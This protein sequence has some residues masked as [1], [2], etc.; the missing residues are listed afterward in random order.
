MLGTTDLTDY[1][2]VDRL[3]RSTAMLSPRQPCL[4]REEA[5]AVLDQLLELLKAQPAG[6]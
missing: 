6:G 3:R 4:N 5:L 1:Y 2:A